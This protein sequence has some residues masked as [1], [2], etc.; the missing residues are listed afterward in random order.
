MCHIARTH[1]RGDCRGLEILSL[2]FFFQ[3]VV[4]PL[5]RRGL[6]LWQYRMSKSGSTSCRES[7]MRHV[8]AKFLS[9]SNIPLFSSGS[10]NFC[11]FHRGRTFL[12]YLLWI[13]SPPE[14]TW[15]I[16]HQTWSY[17]QSINQ[18]LTAWTQVYIYVSLSGS[19]TIDLKT[20]G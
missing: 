9:S 1:L 13:C 11:D 3:L 8:K 7:L 19:L 18:S 4:T 5:Q 20:M 17:Q 16:C 12:W 6:M 2:L 15:H 14:H 10:L